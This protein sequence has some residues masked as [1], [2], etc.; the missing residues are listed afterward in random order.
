M[1]IPPA[2]PKRDTVLLTMAAER[3]GFDLKNQA[4]LVFIRGYYLDSLGVRGQND[5]NCYDDAAF[6]LTPD[7]FDSWNANTDPSFVKKNGKS[8]AALVP[9]VITFY[10]SMHKIGKP[11][12]YQALRPYPEGIQ[13]RCLRDGVPSLCSHTNCHMGGLNLG[14]SGVTWS[15]GC[16]TI[17]KPQYPDWKSR[18]WAAIDKYNTGFS[19]N[20]TWSGHSSKLIKAGI[21]ENK[22]INGRQQ[23]VD[24]Y[25][26]PI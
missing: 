26:R 8:L 25:G 12:A 16:L 13:L 1:I 3:L 18:V 4:Y 10:P 11:G 14:K 21:I 15:E 22:L 7:G 23:W 19:G 2:R 5:I 9:Q 20:K 6:L 24:P 17:P